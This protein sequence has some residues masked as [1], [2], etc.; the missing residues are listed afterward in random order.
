MTM[1]M[2]NKLTR[3]SLLQA[4]AVMAPVAMTG[5]ASLPQPEDKLVR[6]DD[7]VARALLYYPNS[8]DVPANNPLA[9]AHQPSQTCATCIHIRGNAGD[10]VRKCPTFPGRLVNAEGWCSLWAPG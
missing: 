8:N 1:T 4:A 9:A 7:P 5:C 6:A 2:K 10:S 3:R